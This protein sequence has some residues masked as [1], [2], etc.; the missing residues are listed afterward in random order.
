MN[1][2]FY[3]LLSVPDGK[4]TITGAFN[5]SSTS[6]RL[7]WTPPPERTIHGEF[8]G[9]KITYRPRDRPE[10]ER[11]IILRDPNLRVGFLML[12]AT[13]GNCQN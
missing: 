4:P 1:W 6:I 12:F 3:Y 9:Y 13:S 10:E 11:E 7:E 8:L 5:T 2:K